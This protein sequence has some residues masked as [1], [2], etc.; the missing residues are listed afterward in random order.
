[1]NFNIYIDDEL[2]TNLNSYA[3]K[4]GISRNSLIRKALEVFIRNEH[5]GWPKEIL[6]FKGI[7]DFPAFEASRTELKAPKEDPFQ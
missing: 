1:M 5:S 3:G 7:P 2:G 4:Q 6:T